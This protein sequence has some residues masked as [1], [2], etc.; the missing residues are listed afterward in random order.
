MSKKKSS[1]H[2]TDAFIRGLPTPEKGNRLFYDDDV[3]GFGARVTAGGARS[4]VLNY[5]TLRRPRTS[6][7]NW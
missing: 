1:R 3:K 5:L 7:H 2:L 6:I 4:F